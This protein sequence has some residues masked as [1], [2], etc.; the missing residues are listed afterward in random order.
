MENKEYTISSQTM[1]DIMDKIPQEKWGF[2]IRDM[3]AMLNQT[4]AVLT[5][6]EA[7]SNALE[8]GLPVSELV[9]MKDEIVWIDD[10]KCEN[11]IR[12]SDVDGNEIG[13]VKFEDEK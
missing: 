3:E 8:L 11:E 10:G 2:V 7:T 5:V 1:R 4:S 9:Q 13:G 6:I 12:F